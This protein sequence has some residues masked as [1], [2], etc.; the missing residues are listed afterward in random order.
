MNEA[1]RTSEDGEDFQAEEMHL[2]TPESKDVVEPSVEESDTRE[3]EAQYTAWQKT[4]SE[5]LDRLERDHF[6][7]LKAAKMAADKSG[8]SEGTVPGNGF[9]DAVAE[10]REHLFA[11]EKSK[12]DRVELIES[13]PVDYLRE[14]QD[15]RQRRGILM[16]DSIHNPENKKQ[17]SI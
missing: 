16:E 3:E 13:V 5:T 9:E 12:D 17:N 1:Q 14:A 15:V 11:A 6:Y 7:H 2:T 10:E 4:F 8:D